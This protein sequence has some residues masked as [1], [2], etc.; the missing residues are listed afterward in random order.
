MNWLDIVIIILLIISAIS[1]LISG[2]IKSAFSLAGLLGGIFLAGRYYV[3]FSGLFGFIN[4]DNTARIV[5]FIIIFV[6]VMIV[7]TILGIVFTKIISAVLLGWINRLLGA[8]LGVLLGA[9][10]I[11][12]LL[13]ILVKYTGSNSIITDSAMASFLLDR[14]PLVLALLPP[15]FN[16]VQQFFK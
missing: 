5:A 3:A 16:S 1:G 12:A 10:F 11:G 9:I 8:A 6:A 14:V 2:F 4:N 13:A 7:A 15:E